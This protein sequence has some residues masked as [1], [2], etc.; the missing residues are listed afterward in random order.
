VDHSGVT[1]R[2]T[3][4][5]NIDS[6]KRSSPA[7]AREIQKRV[8]EEFIEHFSKDLAVVGFER[9]AEAGVYLLG[10]WESK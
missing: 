4:P 2:I 8:S 6:L 1:A 3:V 10:P 5:A 9:T 7:Q